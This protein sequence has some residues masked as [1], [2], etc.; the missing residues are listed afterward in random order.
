[1]K[2]RMNKEKQKRTAQSD[3][4]LSLSVIALTGIGLLFAV[5]FFVFLFFFDKIS[6]LAGF[7]L[8]FAVGFCCLLRQRNHYRRGTDLLHQQSDELLE[9][10][11]EAEQAKNDALSANAAKTRFLAH[12]SHEIRTPINSIIGMDEMILRE[13]HES[14]IREYAADI[15]QASQS[16]L[17][18]INDI[19]DITRIESQKIEL[20]PVE[21]KLG[22]LI[23]GLMEMLSLRASS[24]NLELKTNIADNLPSVLYGDEVRIRQILT[25]LMTNAIKYTHEGCVT[26][27]V[28]GRIKGDV[29]HLHFAVKDTGIGIR[30]EDIHKLGNSFERI[31]E[32]RNRNIEGSGLGLTITKQLL[33]L[34]GSRLHIDSEYGKGSIFSFELDQT[35]VNTAPMKLERA[36]ITAVERNV[37]FIA[38][39]AKIL[40]VDD[41]AMN[42]RVIR[43]LLK[44]T[45]IRIEE[46]DSG[47]KCLE[48]VANSHYDLIFLDHMMPEMDGV[49]AFQIMQ[50]W[51]SFPCRDTPKIMLTANALAEAEKEYLAMGFD[52]FLA[53]P[54]VLRDL[55]AMIQKLLPDE[56]VTVPGKQDSF[57]DST[58]LDKDPLRIEN[59]TKVNG[60]FWDVASRYFDNAEDLIHAMTDFRDSIDG[61]CQ[62]FEMIRL[63]AQTGENASAYTDRIR[64]IQSSAASIGAM[65]LAGVCDSVALAL[66][67]GH[68]ENVLAML[69]PALES[70]QELKHNLSF[71]IDDYRSRMD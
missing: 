36:E 57:S 43:G 25:N 23:Q 4:K 50:H 69:P 18:I 63:F 62:M 8:A 56:L 33:N 14:N 65:P 28:N 12:M 70:L 64:S 5:L 61:Y 46:A 66:H 35:I 15:R 53:K 44:K 37:P 38:P 13:C 7:S 31:E 51:D 11:A 41:N 54:V 10:R 55:E 47:K 22:E 49:E 19:L 26:L 30:P 71:V 2:N 1:M 58:D 16:L 20:I 40:I 48:L 60:L 24:K 39:N 3:H 21:Y 59:L 42:R 45:K 27:I 6:F 67:G 52:G 68:C 34:M 9:A 17:Y 32:S 29:L